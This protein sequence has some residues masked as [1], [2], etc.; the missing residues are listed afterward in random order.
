MKVVLFAS[1]RER[2]GF[3]EIETTALPSDTPR[4]IVQRVAPS[5]PLEGLRAAVDLEYWDWDQPV[6]PASELAVIPPVSGG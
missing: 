4:A 1:A 5:L 6:G 2:A 3:A